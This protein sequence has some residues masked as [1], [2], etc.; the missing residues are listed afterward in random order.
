M[1]LS[2]NLSSGSLIIVISLNRLFLIHLSVIKIFHGPTLYRLYILT[3]SIHTEGL[4]RGAL[5]EQ[6]C[7][8]LI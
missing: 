6:Y 4:E 2:V 3:F 7:I 8:M 1:M 5:G